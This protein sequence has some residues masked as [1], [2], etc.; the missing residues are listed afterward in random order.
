MFV[1]GTFCEAGVGPLTSV[2][3]APL[4][5]DTVSADGT[6]LLRAVLLLSF[7]VTVTVPPLFTVVGLTT[8]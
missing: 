5:V 1:P 6:T 4:V 7:I 8:I 2:A 3:V